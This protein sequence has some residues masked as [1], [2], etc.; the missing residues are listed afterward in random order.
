MRDVFTRREKEPR[1]NEPRVLTHCIKLNL[2]RSELPSDLLHVFSSGLTASW[3]PRLMRHHSCVIM[4]FPSGCVLTDISTAGEN[5]KQQPSY[6]FQ[7]NL[8]VGKA[9]FY[10]S[11]V[12]HSSGFPHLV[13]ISG[14]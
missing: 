10:D 11:S 1:E 3:G 5:K 4:S 12:Q 8:C 2:S 13:S 7:C 14:G 9:G 6:S